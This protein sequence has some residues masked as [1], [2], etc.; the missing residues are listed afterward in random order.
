[1]SL[2]CASGRVAAIIGIGA[3]LLTGCGSR[4]PRPATVVRALAPR[5]DLGQ[6]R[7]A[8]IAAGRVFDDENACSRRYMRADDMTERQIIAARRDID[9]YLRDQRRHLTTND[10]FFE[11][12]YAICE[13]ATR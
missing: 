12:A 9:R 2:R 10:T 7:M 11:Q 4:P 3:T 5:L 8:A 13:G 1:V 6:Q